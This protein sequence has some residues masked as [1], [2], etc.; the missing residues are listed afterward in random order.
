MYNARYLCKI[1]RKCNFSCRHLQKKGNDYIEIIW[2]VLLETSLYSSKI[3]SRRTVL[4]WLK[5]KLQSA[6][7]SGGTVR[8]LVHVPAIPYGIDF[9]CWLRGHGFF[10]VASDHQPPRLKPTTESKSAQQWWQC[11][12]VCHEKKYGSASRFEYEKRETSYSQVS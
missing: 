8:V 6:N 10:V 1:A 2:R 4:L 5:V 11:K 9:W 7:K 3:F 12:S